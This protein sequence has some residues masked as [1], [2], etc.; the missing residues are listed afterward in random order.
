MRERRNR[1]SAPARIITCISS[2]QGACMPMR[3]DRIDRGASP[4]GGGWRWLGLLGFLMFPLALPAAEGD[5]YLKQ[6]QS[7]AFKVS[8]DA[9]GATAS[10]GA[11]ASAAD[12]ETFEQEL[13]GQYRG[14]YLFY[15][16]LPR[17]GQ[18]EIFL[19]YQKGAS[20]GDIRKKI[21]NRFLHSE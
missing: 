21:M 2:K 8:D 17:R 7:E 14:S 12:I 20:I 3:S 11:D 6:I 4:G 19:E 15:K 10:A 1:I 18:E 5:D 9:G 16:K 13:E